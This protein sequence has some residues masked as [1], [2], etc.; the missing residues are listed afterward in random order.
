MI[1]TGFIKD[2]FTAK[3]LLQFSTRD[4]LDYSYQIFNVIENPD[5]SFYNIMMMAYVRRNYPHRAFHFYKL[6]LY[7]NVGP[8]VYTYPFLV[9]AC[10]IRDSL[11]E[12][13]QMHNHVL[14]L[15]FDSC[16][17]VRSTFVDMYADCSNFKYAERVFEEG[18]MMDSFVWYSLLECCVF[19][20]DLKK[21]EYIYNVMPEKDTIASTLM[22]VSFWRF[23]KLEKAH[24]LINEIPKNDTVSWSALIYCFEKGYRQM[25]E[26]A[27]DLFIW[28]HADG[29]RI[30]EHVVEAIVLVCTNF[31]NLRDMELM[32]KLIHNLV[33]KIGVECDVKLQNDMICMYNQC[34]DL[35]SARN[36]FDAACWLDEDSW[37]YM[38][39]VYLDCGLYDSAK[40]LF[41]SMPKEDFR[42]CIDMISY[43]SRQDCFS[44]SLALFHK[45]V[46]SGVVDFDLHIH[47][48]A[49][50]L[51]KCVFAYVIKTSYGSDDSSD[52]WSWNRLFNF[53]DE[54]GF[55]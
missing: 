18:P 16:V 4:Y 7:R 54:L 39:G 15:G 6:M 1:L 8:N 40:A 26:E 10:A 47:F 49:R 37:R 29:I 38:L 25:Y 13:K 43:Y 53:I 48:A 44:E 11:Y 24:Q 52:Q 23:G 41:E 21:A 3:R 20:W 27:L 30:D 35:L 55:H 22:I 9:E 14:K 17:H 33:V 19:K 32:G 42:S 34:K 12:G 51:G 46:H 5:A 28:M 2:T 50:D 45:I 36:L 31:A